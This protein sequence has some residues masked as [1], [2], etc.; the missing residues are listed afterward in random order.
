[1]QHVAEI[2]VIISFPGREWL[3][4]IFL[5]SWIKFNYLRVLKKFSI[6]NMNE[7]EKKL[8]HRVAGDVKP[9]IAD[10]I[11]CF[12]QIEALKSSKAEII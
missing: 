7:V 2:I 8:I 9:S 5:Y 12:Q 3:F 4:D 10:L 6:H 11:N 1:M